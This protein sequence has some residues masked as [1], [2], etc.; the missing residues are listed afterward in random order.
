M[1]NEES[2]FDDGF[3]AN[4][5]V[6]ET[7]VQS[8][9]GSETSTQTPHKVLVE[10]FTLNLMIFSLKTVESF[11]ISGLICASVKCESE[12]PRKSC[13]TEEN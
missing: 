5:R 10:T 9:F 2:I 6:R 7:N 11:L 8:D 4:N 1:E 13:E 3:C 12:K